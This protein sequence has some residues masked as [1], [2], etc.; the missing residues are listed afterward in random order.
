MNESTYEARIQKLHD[1]RHALLERRKQRGESALSIDMEL[2]VVRS[3]LIALYAQHR[4]QSPG[5]K[6]L[7]QKTG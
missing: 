4:A 1:H 5:N 6:P 3:E 2:D 7:R